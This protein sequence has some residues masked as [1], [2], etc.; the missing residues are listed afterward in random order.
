M[1]FWDWLTGKSKDIEVVD[2][3]WLNQEAK[4]QGI[5]REIAEQVYASPVV[6]AAAHFSATLDRLRTESGQCNLA[7]RHQV[8][9]LSSADFLRAL[10]AGNPSPVTLVQADALVPDEFPTPVADEEPP[11]SILVAERHFLRSHDERIEDFARGLGR[12]CRLS[13]HLSLED[14]LMKVFVGEWVGQMLRN[15]GMTDSQPI[16]SAIVGRRIKDAQAKLAKR[17]LDERKADSAEEWLQQNV[18]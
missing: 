15:L 8:N 16:E 17:A 6:L 14:P 12:R 5:C 11:M 1:G 2:R 9:R 13:F 4:F 10:K 3:I 7:H 18:P